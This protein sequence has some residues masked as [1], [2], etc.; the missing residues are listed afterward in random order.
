MSP[1]CDGS[2]IIIGMGISPPYWRGGVNDAPPS[3]VRAG[4]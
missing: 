4:Y 1:I 2:P 3:L